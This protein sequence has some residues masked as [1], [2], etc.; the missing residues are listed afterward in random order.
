M[1][2]QCAP[3]FARITSVRTTV[4][5]VG[6]RRL[7]AGRPGGG[8]QLARILRR[9]MGATYSP[10]NHAGGPRDPDE[11]LPYSAAEIER[12]MRPRALR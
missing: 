7:G 11:G 10:P 12:A 4:A 6:L 2:I 9:V 3:T 1:T 5:S 8:G